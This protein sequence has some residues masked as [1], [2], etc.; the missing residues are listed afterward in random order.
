[1]NLL[2]GVI[3]PAV[4]LAAGVVFY[5]LLTPQRMTMPA[6]TQDEDWDMIDDSS[7]DSFPASDPPSFT[8]TTSLGAPH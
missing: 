8:P 1:M 4:L 5:R 6:A 3:V 2:R 7:D